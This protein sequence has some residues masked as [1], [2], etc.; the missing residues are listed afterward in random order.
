MNTR[1]SLVRTMSFAFA[2]AAGVSASLY[3][4]CSVAAQ[5]SDSM[6][7]D[8]HRPLAATLL[9][10]VKVFARATDPGVASVV[11]VADD[12]PLPVT[13]LPVVR[14]S[15]NLPALSVTRLPV[16]RVTA[17]AEPEFARLASVEAGVVTV[18][19]DLDI[20]PAWSRRPRPR[21]SSSGDW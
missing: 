15:G 5:N 21:R 11:R 1:T 16:V 12:K 7:V 2:A 18:P 14:V 8:A 6:S 10:K 3:P 20:D 13:L 9:P 17:K 4:Q 19:R